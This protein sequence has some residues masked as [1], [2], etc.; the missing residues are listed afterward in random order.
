MI[1]VKELNM[2]YGKRRVLNN[3]SFKI[4][5]GKT[6]GLLGVNGAGKS[7]LMNIITGYLK[8]DQGEIYIDNINMRK[9]P[10]EGKKKIGYLPELPPL[11]RDMRV[12]EYLSFVAELKG[13]QNRKEEVQRVIALMD[14]SHRELDF[15]KNLSKGLQQRVGFAQA[16]LGN[17]SVLILDEP[18]VGLDPTEAKNTRELI[19]SLQEEKINIIISSHILSEIE[20]LC[21]SILMIKDGSI[22]LDET[23]LN[24]K[25]KGNK[26]MYRLIVKGDLSKIKTALQQYEQIREVEFVCK[27][28]SDVYEFILISKNK[29]DIRDNIIGYLVSKKFSVYGIERMEESLEELFIKMN[30]EE[31]Q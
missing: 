15:I 20:E 3:I 23:T 7:T 24:A 26:C 30:N 31:E 17:P 25:R 13:I 27:R 14:L 2:S 28:E 8:P 12:V 6:V 22:V 10:K 21:G 5:D 16:L 19:R 29:R 9:N 18:L 4:E 11:Y 1:E